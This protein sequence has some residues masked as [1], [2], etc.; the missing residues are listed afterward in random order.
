MKKKSFEKKLKL[1]K[2]LIVNLTTNQ[3]NSVKGGL[4][5]PPDTRFTCTCPTAGCNP[6]DVLKN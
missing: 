1:K 4:V 3:L 2:N 5:K 6:G